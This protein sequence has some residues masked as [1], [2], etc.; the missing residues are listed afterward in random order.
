LG[1]ATQKERNCEKSHPEDGLE[2]KENLRDYTGKGG[3]GKS[4]R[5]GTRYDFQ[6]RKGSFL[7][8][9]R[10]VWGGTSLSPSK[11]DLKTLG[12]VTYRDY[13]SKGKDGNAHVGREESNTCRGEGVESR[14]LK[15]YNL[16]YW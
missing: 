5:K 7:G 3:N 6:R 14:N 9:K 1:P 8:G 15:D 12:E 16:K 13:N 2:K 4:E 10:F 11:K